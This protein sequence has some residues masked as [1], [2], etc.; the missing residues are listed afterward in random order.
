MAE[1]LSIVGRLVSILPK[2]EG[3]GANGHWVRQPFVV[4]VRENNYVTSVCFE[5]WGDTA[6]VLAAFNVNDMISV[7]FRPSSR[8]YNG[9]WYTSLRAWRIV[10]A[11]AE[12]ADSQPA[13]TAFD[14]ES[15]V[16]HVDTTPKESPSQEVASDSGSDEL[17]F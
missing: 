2:A 14:P 17:P 5:A 3:E 11:S 16:T 1:I 9:R 6:N 13:N 12:G 4:E 7:A 10:S 8:E 15:T